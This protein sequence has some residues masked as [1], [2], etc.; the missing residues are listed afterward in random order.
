M[1]KS[2]VYQD[3]T[4][5]LKAFLGTGADAMIT[6]YGIKAGAQRGVKAYALVDGKAIYSEK[7]AEYTF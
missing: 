6:L 4:N 5:E 3:W 1:A 7:T 2:F